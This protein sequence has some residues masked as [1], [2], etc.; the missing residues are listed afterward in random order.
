MGAC[1]HICVW[2][3][4]YAI[5][6][7]KAAELMEEYDFS[8]RCNLSVGVMEPWN[9]RVSQVGRGPQESS[10]PTPCF[11]QDY[12]K[13]NCMTKGILQSLLEL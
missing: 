8:L 1:T 3:Y 11:F 5:K 2:L 4:V 6:L 13:P 12:L 9:H 7:L 10:S